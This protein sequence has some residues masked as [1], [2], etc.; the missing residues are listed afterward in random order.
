MDRPILALPILLIFSA[1][2]I[3]ALFSAPALKKRLQQGRPSMSQLSWL[4]ALAPAAAFILL[5]SLTSQVN[6]GQVLSW[7]I[8]WLPAAGLPFSL[9]LDGLSVFF[10]LI[11]TFI[12]ALIIVYT[13]QYFKG[14]ADA[15]RFL[16]YILLFMGAML[17]LVLAGD[18]ITLFIFWEGTSI[19]SFLLVAYKSK[20]EEARKGA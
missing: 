11:V 12:G 14:D 8:E 18:V 13:G 2:A 17:G 5:L 10:A 4:L 15:W 19:T 1:A 6:Q 3:A 16:T 20:D 7:S 9:Y